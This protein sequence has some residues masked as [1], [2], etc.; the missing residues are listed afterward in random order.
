MHAAFHRPYPRTP[1][2]TPASVLMVGHNETK[3]LV[4]S[5]RSLHE[6]T[7]RNLQIVVVDDGSTEPMT[8]LAL[9]LQQ[10]GLVDTVVSAGIRGGKAAALNL[11]LRYCRHDIIVVAD[12]DTSFDRDAVEHLLRP[13][14][15]DPSIGAVGGNIA[16]RNPRASLLTRFQSLEY[17]SNISLG[18]QFTSMFGILAI[19]SGAFGAYR[20]RG[21]ETVGGWD[22]GPGDDSN[23]TT[24]IR[25]AGWR[26]IFEPQAWALTDV[27]VTDRALDNQR[28]RWNRS[29][30]RNRWRKFRS[31]F[32]PFQHNFS[33]AD[34]VAAIN[35]LWFHLVLTFAWVGYITYLVLNHGADALVL[36]IALHA[37]VIF[38]DYF[39]FAVAMLFVPRPGMWRLLAYVPGM[40]FYVAY[41]M[42]IN[43]LRAYLSELVL[44]R[45][46]TDP[47]YPSKVRDAQDQF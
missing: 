9:R 28:L 24:K 22:V 33:T 31:V 45:S 41:Y 7:H 40:T 6:Q 17:F 1:A 36:L 32:N 29:L 18:R 19:V 30:I 23:V 47:F 34:M 2:T 37:L 13:L 25:R 5:V 20:R 15:H 35:L 16:V 44:R 38:F 14:V 43:R 11:G 46:Y 8:E 10:Q 39:E 12:I 21:L 27:P 42:R 4:R 3:G 26:I